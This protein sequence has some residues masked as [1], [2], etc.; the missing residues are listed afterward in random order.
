M[1][2]GRF[3]LTAL[4][5]LAGACALHA[6]EPFDDPQLVSIRV[7]L[8]VGD[9]QPT[10]W[11]GKL[12]V[13]GGE[14]AGLASLRPRPDDSIAGV[15]WEM[16]SWQGP[17]FRYPPTKPQPV[18]GIPV[19]IFSPGLVAAVRARGRTRV[20][21]ETEQGNFRVDLRNLPLGRTQRFLGGRAVV[22]RTLA[23]QKI[24]GAE[25][26][27]DFASIT[28]G[29]DGQLWVAWTAYRG[30]A[31]EVLLR[32]YDGRSWGEIETVTE[33]P[34]DVFL[35][36]AARGG[37][38]RIRVVWS[39]QVDGNRDLYARSLAGDRW[40]A[41]ERLTSAAEP[42]LYHNVA[43]DSEGRVWV[44]WQGFRE[45]RSD[46]FA[47]HHDGERW[48]PAEKVST[49]QAND[50]EPAVAADGSG[51]VYVAW[52][53]YDK[54]NYD[55]LTRRYNGAGWED[56]RPLAD[57][58]KFEAHVTLTCD[59]D[60]R[61]WAAWSES[62]T[63][64]GK[65]DGFGLEQEGTRLYAWRSMAVAVLDGGRRLEPTVALEAALPADLPGDRSDSPT[66]QA[67]GNG[68]VWVF[69]RRRNPR[70]QDIVSDFYAFYATW[71]LWGA[72]YAGGAWSEPV[73]FPH[74][75]GRLD[76][77]SGFTQTGDGGIAAAWPT[78]NRDFADMLAEQYDI[79]V[80]KVPA[81]PRRGEHALQP[82]VQP[83]ITVYPI[84]PNETQDLETIRNYEIVSGGKTYK[85]YRGDTH[86]HTEFSMDG[87]NDGSLLQAYRYAIDA[88]SL[89]FYANSEHNY[90][91]GPDVEYHDF[92]LQQFADC[93]HLPGSFTP[94]F[95]YE[96]S[97]RYPNGHRNII[98][99]KR[100]V[101][102][103]RISR[104]EFGSPLFPFS[105]EE[106]TR[107]FANPEPVGTK[108][109]YAYLKENDGIA[110]S[111][112]SATNMGTD[113]RDNDPAVEPL[114][115]IYQGDRVSAEYEGAPRAA[116]AGNPRSAPGGFRPAGYVWNAWAKGYK[117]GVQAASDHVSTHIS[118]ALHDFRECRPRRAARRHAQ[119]ALL[120]RDGQH[121]AGLPAAVGRQG[122]PAGR[123]RNRIRRLPLVG[124]GD[125]HGA[126]PPDRHR[127][128]PG[129]RP[130][131]PQPRPHVSFEFT[132]A[133]PSPGESYYYVRVQQDDGQIAWS[134]PI[135][136]TTG[137]AR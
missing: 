78:D 116:Y 122:V 19:N 96:R 58:P 118:Y 26:Q 95:A 15:S 126:D 83:E 70:I 6:R 79:R 22:D 41:V 87:F 98:F 49:S 74:S 111:H 10:R 82:R 132:D 85:I 80:A 110:I 34:G 121:R 68:G 77:R 84:H 23:T 125:R 42:D 38:G 105:S 134:S 88:A 52:D 30:G 40:S 35:A 92:L 32:H 135:W 11:D 93:F 28:S 45:G 114:V 67:D 63:L 18:T 133:D 97:V 47:R 25:H 37:D 12:S 66:I 5:A 36:K 62:G 4:L 99:A 1:S 75:R 59:A 112:T 13:S 91:G 76:M 29:P 46:I 86:R 64:W 9:K 54:G 8:G 130:D 3:S 104:E 100:G 69:F 39:D 55:I 57:T 102:P 71:E 101:R 137:G 94:L 31:N 117:L 24:S 90:L 65:D 48:S 136:V 50:W 14:P 27:N 129:V 89:D 16:A 17:N 103:F 2:A 60:D 106:V 81:A 44:V 127:Q 56:V 51:N 33:K 108:D 21:F 53:T 128:E 43:T 73:Y 123:H 115:E 109:L 61:L 72:R 124:A 107:R 119:A 7:Q 113:W 131:P 120:R 20:A